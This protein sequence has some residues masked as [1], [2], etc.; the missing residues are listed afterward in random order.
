MIDVVSVTR[1]ENIP[2]F[3][4]IRIFTYIMTTPYFIHN[5]NLKKII[6]LKRSVTPYLAKY[7]VTLLLKASARDIH[8][9]I[10]VSCSRVR[11]DC[12][13]PVQSRNVEHRSAMHSALPCTHIMCTTENQMNRLNDGRLQRKTHSIYLRS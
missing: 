4:E 5:K 10:A 1:F 2:S 7:E 13:S 12:F 11:V 3:A 6:H 8:S 9:T